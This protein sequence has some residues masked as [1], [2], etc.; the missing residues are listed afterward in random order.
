MF[1]INILLCGPNFSTFYK[2]D[3]E[4]MRATW[5]DLGQKSEISN[6]ALFQVIPKLHMTTP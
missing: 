5:S 1:A 3:V 4:L 6:Y 2:I